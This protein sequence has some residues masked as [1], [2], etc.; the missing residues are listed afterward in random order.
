M[1]VQLVCVVAAYADPMLVHSYL[2]SGRPRIDAAL[3][4]EDEA[5]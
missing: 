4:E 3:K 1:Y 2:F 5:K